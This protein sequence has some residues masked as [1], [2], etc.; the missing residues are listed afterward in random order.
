[1]RA[2]IRYFFSVVALCLVTQGV[3]AKDRY[4]TLTAPKTLPQF[5]LQDQHGNDFGLEK[6]QGQWSIV[7][8]GF[9]S[10]PDVCPYILGNLEA[11]RAD[12]GLRLPPSRI[13]VI[14][15]V[16]VDPARDAPVLKDYMA[17]FHPEYVGVTGKPQELER[18]VSSLGGFF[19]LESP[20]PGRDHYDVQH[21]AVVYLINPEGQLVATM[22]PP[23][24]AHEAG[25]YLVQVIR[26]R[27]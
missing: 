10:C 26:G 6:L 12:L 11:V 22:S 23:F 14:V 5:A 13:P 19:R 27:S 17:H 24:N 4:N 1:M 3:W 2:V 15:F 8:L 18:F 20:R 25:E 21:T 16:A 9:T 7:T